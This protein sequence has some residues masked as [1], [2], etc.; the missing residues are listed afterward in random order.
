MAKTSFERITNGGELAIKDYRADTG[1]SAN[2]G[3]HD[4]VR[5]INQIITLCAVGGHH[6]NEIFERKIKEITLISRTLLLHAIRHWSEYTTTMTWP[7]ALKEASFRL[8]EFSIRTDER[9]HEATFFGIDGNIID[10]EMIH[11]FG[12]PCFVL[13]ARLQSG[14]ST[15]PK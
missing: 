8:N 4:S 1:R 11:T 5:D 13:D 6:Q 3:F 12:C 2:K 10:P 15:C 14:L 9:N 7:F